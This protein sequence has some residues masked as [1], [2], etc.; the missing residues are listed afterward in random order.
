MTQEEFFPYHNRHIVF[1][2]NDGQEL[3]GVL[4]DPMNSFETGKPSTVYRFVP[5]NKMIEWKIADRSNNYEMMKIIEKDLD[6]S[7]ITW[8]QQLNF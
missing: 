7:L 1:K 3:S 6:I 2:L 8:A 5:T 4:M